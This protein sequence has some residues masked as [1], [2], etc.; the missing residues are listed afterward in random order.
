M[1]NKKWIMHAIEA[2][3]ALGLLY[4]GLVLHTF[5]YRMENMETFRLGLGALVVFGG[6]AL[7]RYWINRQHL[8]LVF[9]IDR[10]ILFITYSGMDEKK[11]RYIQNL[12]RQY[13]P[14]ERVY[15]QKASS[16]IAGNCGPGSFGLM[17][18]RRDDA[19]LPLLPGDGPGRCR[20]AVPAA[21]PPA[22]V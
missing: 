8:E 10:R 20:I 17:F 2:V 7:A 9:D 12:V 19:S 11:L 22:L 16:A 13:C 18:M 5:S 14:F 21:P 1:L 3:Y 6:S 15:L 4:H